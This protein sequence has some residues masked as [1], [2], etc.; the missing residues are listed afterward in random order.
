LGHIVRNADAGASHNLLDTRVCGL[1][2]G[3]AG[4]EQPQ[5]S[6]QGAI[7]GVGFDPAPHPGVA[8]RA[9]L[10]AL[11]DLTHW[12]RAGPRR[13]RQPLPQRAQAGFAVDEGELAFQ[14]HADAVGRVL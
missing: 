10:V 11:G 1:Q 9:H 14:H 4:I 6:K 7:G 3:W 2:P 5:A 8:V 12:K 13:Q